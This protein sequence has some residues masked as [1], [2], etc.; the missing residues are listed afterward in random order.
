MKGVQQCENNVNESFAEFYSG[1]ICNKNGF[2]ESKLSEVWLKTFTIAHKLCLGSLL[3]EEG[4]GGRR[5]QGGSTISLEE[6]GA[7]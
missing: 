3:E 4:Q 2:I 6:T 1:N 5:W 7:L